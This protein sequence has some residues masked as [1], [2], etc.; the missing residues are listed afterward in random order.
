MCVVVGRWRQWICV[1]KRGGNASNLRMMY[2]NVVGSCE[3][4][5]APLLW[6]VCAVVCDAVCCSVLQCVALCCIALHVLHCVALCCIVLQ[7]LTVCF[8][9][10]HC[11][12]L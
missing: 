6:C 1:G 4:E 5:D 9:V 12:A 10:L 2:Q 3:S 7:L 11:V 8:R